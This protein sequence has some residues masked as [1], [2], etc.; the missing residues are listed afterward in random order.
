MSVS[1]PADE[2]TPDW[3]SY[4]DLQNDVL[5]WLQITASEFAAFP[6][7]KQSTLQDTVDAVCWEA[8]D[9]LGRPIAP[10][11]FYRKFT[12]TG[13]NYTIELPY[14]PVLSIDVIQETWGLN[15]QHTLIYQTPE[16]QGGAGEQ[17]YTMDWIEGVIIRTYQGLIARPFFVGTKNLEVTWTAGYN[18]VPRSLIMMTKDLIKEWWVNTQDASRSVQMPGEY[19]EQAPSPQWSGLSRRVA[20]IF[21]GYAQIG[22]GG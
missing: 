19:G 3:Q 12:N 18:P 9:F 2:I 13:S 6:A 7:W 8:Q 20:Q 5:P 1:A 16:N 11:Q 4:L 14:S 10:T 22:I 17:M 21:D 15:G